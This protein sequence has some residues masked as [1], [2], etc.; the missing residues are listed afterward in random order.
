[1]VFEGLSLG[2][3]GAASRLMGSSHLSTSYSPSPLFPLSL[4]YT[5]A[6]PFIADKSEASRKLARAREVTS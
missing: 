4:P 1:M 5:F 6:F 2:S 3:I